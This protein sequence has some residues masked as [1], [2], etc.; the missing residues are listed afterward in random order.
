MILLFYVSFYA[1]CTNSFT[2]VRLFVPLLTHNDMYNTG[3]LFMAGLHWEIPKLHL[4]LFHLRKVA[5]AQLLI[6]V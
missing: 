6:Y 1:M 5:I 4:E 3:S 2:V